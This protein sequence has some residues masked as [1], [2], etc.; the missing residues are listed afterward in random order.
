MVEEIGVFKVFLCFVCLKALAREI[1]SSRRTVKRLY[2]NKAQVNSISM[3]IGE[4]IGNDQKLY[5]VFSLLLYDTG[6]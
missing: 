1:V 3:H 2:E 5:L 4:S 6:F